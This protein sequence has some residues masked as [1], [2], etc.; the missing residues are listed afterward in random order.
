[1]ETGPFDEFRAA[2]QGVVDGLV[3]GGKGEEGKGKGEEGKGE[4]EEGKGEGEEGRVRSEK[5][6]KTDSSSQSSED[7]ASDSSDDSSSSTNQ[8]PPDSHMTNTVVKDTVTEA[9]QLANQITDLEI[10]DP[11]YPEMT[12]CVTLSLFSSI[13]RMKDRL[14]EAQLLLEVSH[15]T[16]CYVIYH[17]HCSGSTLR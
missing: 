17:N 10:Y 11:V 7:S 3:G 13:V 5:S 16:Q 6:S 9:A 8:N 14:H 15:V 12:L 1:M 2:F 4:G